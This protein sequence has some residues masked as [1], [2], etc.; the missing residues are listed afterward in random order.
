MQSFINPSFKTWPKKVIDYLLSIL[1]GLITAPLWLIICPIL[2]IKMGQ[3]I[4]FKQKRIGKDGHFFWMFKVRS[5]VKNAEILRERFQ[6]QYQ[7][8]NSAPTPMFKINDDP[9]FIKIKLGKKNGQPKE[10]NLGKFLSHTGIDELPQLW[11]I[12]RGEMSF[13][14]PR[15]LPINEANE[16]KE[17]AP[18]WYAWRHSVSPGIFSIWAL[19]KQRHQSLKVWRRLEVDSLKLNLFQQYLLITKVFYQQ[20]KKMLFFWKI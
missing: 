19:D 6:D 8:L 1:I 12:L 7:Q 14:G 4:I 17:L 13:F 11:N 10:F 15:P 2:L 20:F 5:M 18:G 16:L 3:P 9:R